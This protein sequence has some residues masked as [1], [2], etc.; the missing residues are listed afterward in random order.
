MKVY[1]ALAEQADAGHEVLGVYRGLGAIREEHEVEGFDE[2]VGVVE[3]RTWVGKKA[4]WLVVEEHELE[5]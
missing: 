1:V 3:P 5:G 2:M 4:P